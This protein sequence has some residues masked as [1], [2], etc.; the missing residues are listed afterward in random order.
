[1]RNEIK[2]ISNNEDSVKVFYLAEAGLEYGRSKLDDDVWDDGKLSSGEW[3]SELAN[4]EIKVIKDDGIDDGDYKIKST[5]IYNGLSR[6]V[7]AKFEYLEASSNGDGSYQ[8]VEG[9]WL[10]K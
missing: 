9:S 7:G 5:A 2:L 10:E 3:W 1:M 6:T 8:Q 4:Q